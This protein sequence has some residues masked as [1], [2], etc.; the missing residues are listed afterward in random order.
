M[1]FPAQHPIIRAIYIL[2]QAILLL[3]KHRSE[4]IVMAVF[5]SQIKGVSAD[6]QRLYNHE[7]KM[8]PRHLG[9]V[10]FLRCHIG[11]NRLLH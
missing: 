6:H 4:R 5:F 3:I 11:R 9:A 8:D 7:V 2:I 1:L 10:Y